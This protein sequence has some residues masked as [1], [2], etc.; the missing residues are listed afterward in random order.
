[1]NKQTLVKVLC[2]SMAFA[3]VLCCGKQKQAQRYPRVALIMK[4][5]SNPF[6]KT[7][8]EGATAAAARLNVSLLCLSVPRETDFEQQA[9][10]VRDQ[11]AQGVNAII[12]APADSKAIVSPLLE[13]QRKGIPIINI[14]NRIDSATAERA[15]LKALTF[16]G[17]DNAEG[18]EKSTDFLIKMIGGKG[19]VAMLEGIRGAT[20]AEQ[21]KIGFLRAVARTNGAVT[22]ADMDT[23]EWATEL[24]RTKME[25][26]LTRHPDLAGV[27]CANDMMAFGAIAAIQAAGKSGKVVVTAYDN[28][29]AAQENILAGLMAA[30]IEQHPDQMGALGVEHALKAIRGEQVPPEIKVPTDLVTS[31]TLRKARVKKR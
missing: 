26:L 2:V 9:Q 14:D 15:G 7:M 20:N 17:P 13:A 23:A 4:A 30:T 16:I 11:V 19:K 29:A 8:A 22:I 10:Y 12:I 31:E 6:F 25:G 1:M 5:I 3:L 21:R 24:A 18:A 28:L 27:F